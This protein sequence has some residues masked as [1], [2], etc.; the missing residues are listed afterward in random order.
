VTFG[1]LLNTKCKE[2]ITK[3]KVVSHLDKQCTVNIVNQYDTPPNPPMQPTP[4]RGPKIVG[5]L[6]TGFVLRTI[7][8]YSGGA[9]YGPAVG[10]QACALATLSGGQPI[11]SIPSLLPEINDAR[12]L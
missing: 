1:V 12:D 2:F 11:K 5:V 8:T 9:A 3:Q 6:E 10:R 4:L 7:P